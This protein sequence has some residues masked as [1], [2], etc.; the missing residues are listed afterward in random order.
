MNT[1][2][3]LAAGSGER[4]ARRTPDKILAPLCG[5]PV[6]RYSVEAFL[7]AG[8]IQHFTVVYRDENQLERLRGAFARINPKGV[9]ITWIRGGKRRQDSVF[10]A[11]EIQEPTCG[12]VFIH[13]CARP[14]IAAEALHI[15]HE[16]VLRD[17]A[18][19]LAHPVTDTIKRLPDPDQLRN[20]LPDDLDRSRLWAMETPQAFAFSSILDAYRKI[21]AN[22]HSI[23]DDTAAATH[24]GLRTTLVPN[25]TPNPK[26]TTPEDLDFAAWLLGQS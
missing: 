10:N 3:L 25:P 18:A 16:A 21:Q 17:G 11:L 1:A 8:F 9:T 19:A 23:T 12:R 2:I 22:G 5:W 20:T 26:I 14:L 7:K 13:D 6:F 15:L 4:M 24:A